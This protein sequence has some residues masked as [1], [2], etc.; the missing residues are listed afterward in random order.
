MQYKTIGTPGFS[1][2]CLID[3]SKRIS[4]E[5]QKLYNSGI[6]MIINLIKDSWSDNANARS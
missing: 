6:G 1:T 2:V 5:D 4:N 3:Y